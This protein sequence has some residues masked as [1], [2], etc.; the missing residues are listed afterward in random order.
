LTTRDAAGR[1]NLQ[2]AAKRSSKKGER[3]RA[4]VRDLNCLDPYIHRIVFQYLR[5]L[6]LDRDGFGEEYVTA[7]DGAVDVAATFWRVRLHG[8]GP[9]YREQ[10]AR[11]LLSQSDAA[12]LALLY[13]LRCYFGAHPSLSKWWDFYEMYEEDL[14]RCEEAVVRLIRAVCRAERANRE[15]EPNPESWSAW[16][17][18]HCFTIWR[19]VWFEGAP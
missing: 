8:A 9:N 18:E 17:R 12:L 14:E 10:M 1:I 7:L 5:A 6:A 11:N 19:A 2:L 15:V 16:F 13:E 4:W 3:V